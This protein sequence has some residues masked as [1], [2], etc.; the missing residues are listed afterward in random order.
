[1][2][3]YEVDNDNFSK[4]DI[5]DVINELIDKHIS[6]KSGTNDVNA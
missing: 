4:Q 6:M 3:F 5:G 1:M 2:V